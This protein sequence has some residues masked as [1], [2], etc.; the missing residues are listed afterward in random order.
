M[1][2]YTTDRNPQQNEFHACALENAKSNI[3][4]CNN[5]VK[6]PQP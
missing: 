1:S 5:T 3:I 2:S 4:Q 6:S